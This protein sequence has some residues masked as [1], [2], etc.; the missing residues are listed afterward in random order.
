M[1]A[2]AALEDAHVPRKDRGEHPTLHVVVE[3]A[4]RRLSRL[5]E[6]G[7]HGVIV[8]LGI[9]ADHGRILISH[10]LHA[11]AGRYVGFLGLRLVDTVLDRR[12]EPERRHARLRE[13][14][15]KPCDLRRCQ[16][17]SGSDTG[18]GEVADVAGPL[19]GDLW[20]EASGYGRHGSDPLRGDAPKQL[21][22]AAIARP[23]SGDFGRTAKQARAGSKAGVNCVGGGLEVLRGNVGHRGADS[24]V[25]GP[26]PCGLL[27]AHSGRVDVQAVDFFDEVHAADDFLGA[28]RTQDGTA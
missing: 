6:F 18:G 26:Q 7:L 24:D 17:L 28:A 16:V 4:H 20:D 2:H 22:D 10:R 25:E 11:P 3:H 15:T 12:A 21:L 5:G 14:L 1:L 27:L 9:L 13:L 23:G 19:R 8:H